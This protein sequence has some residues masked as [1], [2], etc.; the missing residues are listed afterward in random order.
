MT[1]WKAAH[2]SVIN[3]AGYPNIKMNDANSVL[4]FM[5]ADMCSEDVDRIANKLWWVSKQDSKS[6]SSLHRQI[7][8]GRTIVITEDPKLHLVWFYG[9][10]FVK[11]I[12]HYIL[13]PVIWQ[14]SMKRLEKHD[15]IRKA[16]MGYLRTYTYLVRS[17]VDFRIAQDPNLHL[18]PDDFTWDKF[19]YPMSGFINIDNKD[20]SGCYSY[21]E[22]RLTVDKA[23]FLCSTAASQIVFPT[24]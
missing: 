11:P 20:V 6:I 24:P 19:C 5:E 13:S 9:R 15:Y 17:E 8:K 23:Q 22:I 14:N 3:L 2:T 10:I 18:V 12:P 7:V 21:G 16:A 4:K 1:L